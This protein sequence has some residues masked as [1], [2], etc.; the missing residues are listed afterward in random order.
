MVTALCLLLLLTACGR[1]AEEIP[2]D[3]GGAAQTEEA[4]TKMQAEPEDEAAG[5]P[6]DAAAGET[7]EVPTADDPQD[8]ELP[9]YDYT[10]S[11][12]LYAAVHRYVTATLPKDYEPSDVS[13]PVVLVIDADEKDPEDILV[14]GD[15]W[16][17]NYKLKD[18]VLET[19][20][21]G[22][23]P[24]CIHLRKTEDGYSAFSMDVTRDG[25]DWMQSAQEIFGDGDRLALLMLVT[26]NENLREAVRSFTIA[27]YAYKN[28]LEIA[29]YQDY[30]WDEVALATAPG[31]IRE[32]AEI[33]L[34]PDEEAQGR[35]ETYTF[36]YDGKPYT[37]VYTADH[38][39]ITDS[40]R[41]TNVWDMQ[42]IA[43][44]LCD[45]HTIRGAD[46]DS[47]RTGED[48]AFEWLQ[49][50]QAYMLLPDGAALKENAA[51]V[52]F[53]PSDIGKTYEEIFAARSGKRRGISSLLE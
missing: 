2:E 42:V 36:S 37:A 49:H 3:P 9:A 43:Q 29:G 8:Q 6:E 28:K 11:D 46:R 34:T 10:G 32:S 5:E 20:S 12:P 45:V 1:E 33:G 25:S 40:Y 52:D 19:E 18:G 22:D 4:G 39:K 17:Y 16:I 41:I 30:G 35:G 7:G 51:D 24:A 50:D 31:L 13:I 23:Y 21:G 15:F 26:A 14:W 47:V 38:W 48:M 27:D 44:A 53:D